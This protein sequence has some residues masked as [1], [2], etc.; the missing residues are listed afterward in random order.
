VSGPGQ[1][2]QIRPELGVYVLGAIAPADRARVSRHLASCPG[3]REDAAGLAGLPALLRSVPAATVLQLSAEC[4]HDPSGPPGPL[5]DGLIGRV[6]AVRRRR[7]WALAAAAAVLAAAAAAGWTTQVLHPAAP[8][9]HTAPGWWAAG[10]FNAATGD[11]ATVRYTPQPWGTEL[12]ASVSGIPP[13]TR[14]QIWA[15]TANGQQAAGGGWTVTRGDPHAWYPA[16]V[17]FPAGSLAGFDITAGGTVLVTI[18]LRPAPR[19]H[20]PVPPRPL[21]AGYLTKASLKGCR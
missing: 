10:G 18:P 14:C 19:P 9:Q 5:V 21:P 16:S 6:A 8:P 2:A 13:G 7:R 12:E 3:C 15:T 20:Q 4:P 1:C 11:H 17:P